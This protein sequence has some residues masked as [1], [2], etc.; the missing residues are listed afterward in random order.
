MLCYILNQPLNDS[1]RINEQ[2]IKYILQPNRLLHMF[3]DTILQASASSMFELT[4]MI[5]LEVL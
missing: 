4:E 3:I 2:Q 5:F 1:I